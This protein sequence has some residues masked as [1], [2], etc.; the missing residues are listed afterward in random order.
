MFLHWVGQFREAISV[1]GGQS[2]KKH[3]QT[4]NIL[5]E[6]TKESILF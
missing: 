2:L 1:T 3:G 4:G 6:L 5:E